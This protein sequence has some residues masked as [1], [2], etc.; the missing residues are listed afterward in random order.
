MSKPL[1]FYILMLLWLVCGAVPYVR[2]GQRP[3]LA[4]SSPSLLLF[5]IILLLGWA[6]FGP[7]IR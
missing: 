4:A 6:V 1:L 2:S 7:P 5:A 3:S